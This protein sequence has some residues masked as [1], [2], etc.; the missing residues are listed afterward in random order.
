[1]WEEMVTSGYTYTEEFNSAVEHWNVPSSLSQALEFYI[2]CYQNTTTSSS[3]L[4]QRR[5]QN[6]YIKTME[7]LENKQVSTV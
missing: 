3:Y 2:A 7:D 4:L 6:K 5:K 1:M